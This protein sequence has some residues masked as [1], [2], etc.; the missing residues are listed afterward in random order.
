MN[1]R[2]QTLEIVALVALFLGIT[3]LTVVGFAYN[4]LP[5]VASEHGPEV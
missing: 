5:E 1:E 2:G 4:W 3:I